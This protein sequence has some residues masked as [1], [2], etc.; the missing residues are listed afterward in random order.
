[1]TNLLDAMTDQCMLVLQKYQLKVISA[2][3]KL[4]SL[5]QLRKIFKN[6]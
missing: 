3:E 6:Y 5:H 1:M 2:R 4:Q